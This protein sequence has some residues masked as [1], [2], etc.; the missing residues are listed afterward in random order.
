MQKSKKPVIELESYCD[1][2]HARRNT[3]WPELIKATEA[4]QRTGAIL[5]IAELGYLTGNPYFMKILIDA[6][7]PLYCCDQSFMTAAVLDA[8]HRHAELHRVLH[9]QAICAGLDK[10]GRVRDRKKRRP[11][12]ESAELLEA[13]AV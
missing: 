4:C 9:S 8:Y 2:V 6:Q 1:W 7:I 3:R 11:A 5:L 13:M 10:K 12:S